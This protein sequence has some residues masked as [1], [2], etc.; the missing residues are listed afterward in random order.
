MSAAAGGPARKR[1]AAAGA[2]VGPLA[3]FVAVISFW[4]VLRWRLLAPNKRFL[5]PYPH[6]VVDQAFLTWRSGSG[7]ATQAALAGG[8]L[9]PQL[10]ALWLSA[11]VA[12]LGLAISVV[13]GVG[14][15]IAMSRARWV[16]RAC[17]PYLVALQATPVLAFVPLIGVVLGFTFRSRV[18][19]CV[20]IS[21]FPIVANTL[22]GIKSVAAAHHDLFTLH[23]A[24]GWARLVKLQLPAALPAMFTGFRI[25]AGL[26]VIGAVVGDFFF[27]K[28]D[29]GIGQL[30]NRYGN[31]LAY[32]QMY[33]SV[34]LA[35][36]LGI[37]VFWLFGVLT[38]VVIGRW[39]E[40]A[41]AR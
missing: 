32:E 17:Y 38:T 2:A 40:A 31:S 11:R 33:G 37:A 20:L 35:S 4:Y 15:A 36:A 9:A 23:R 26:S 6:D 21:L 10:N 28:G 39:D 24:G 27:S 1:G 18:L 12:M 19:V 8:G 29:P 13:V 5:V 22:F 3:V 25:S 14:V 16:E 30:I 34:I 7:G 41:V